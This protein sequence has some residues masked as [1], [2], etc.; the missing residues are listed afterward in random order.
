M[1]NIPPEQLLGGFPEEAGEKGRSKGSLEMD[2]LVGDDLVNQ[3]TH[4][5][6]EEEGDEV[7]QNE[8]NDRS[9]L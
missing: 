9:Q 7:F 6:S 4:P 5:K 2:F 3:K 8:S 1:K